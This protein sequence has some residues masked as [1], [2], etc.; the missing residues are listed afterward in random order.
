MSWYTALS[1]ARYQSN[2]I[3]FEIIGFAVQERY[4]QI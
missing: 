4:I 1:H 2:P 3:E